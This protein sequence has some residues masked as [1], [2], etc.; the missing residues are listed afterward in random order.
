MRTAVITSVLVAFFVIGFLLFADTLDE[1]IATEKGLRWLEEQG[2]LAGIAAVALIASDLFLPM[3]VSGVLAALGTIYGGFV[4]GLYGSAGCIAGGLLA[5]GLVRAMG[6]RAAARIAGEENLVA[7]ERFFTRGGTW[8]IAMTR[9]LPVVSEVLCCLAGL[10]PMPF[11]RFFVALCCGSI[12]FSFMF[13]FYASTA[14]QEPLTAIL[15]AILVP[16]LLLL[17]AWLVFE[18][19][20]RRT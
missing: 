3:P 19:V 11:G 6:R 14:D 15:I 16:A 4:G 2:P 5:Y 13:T 20:S 7:L 8:A 18:R 17:P 9:V 12:P 1:W 10:A